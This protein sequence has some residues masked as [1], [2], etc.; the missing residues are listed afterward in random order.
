MYE[1]THQLMK[2]RAMCWEDNKCGVLEGVKGE[3]RREIDIM[4]L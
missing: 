3:N 2:K 4:I 1:H